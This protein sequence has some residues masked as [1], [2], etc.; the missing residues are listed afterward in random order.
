MNNAFRNLAGRTF[1]LGIGAQKSGTT[2][3]NAYLGRHPA[4]RMSPIKELHFFDTI[5]RPDLCGSWNEE[6]AA[7]LERLRRDPGVDAAAFASAALPLVERVGMSG[8]GARYMAYFDRL[9]A[10][11]APVVGEI[12]PSYSL[13]GEPGLQ[14]VHDLIAPNVGR[15]RILMLM[16][17]PVGRFWSQL[18]HNVRK[19]VLA[20]SNAHYRA[21]LYQAR[22]VERTRYELM[23][24]RLESV[25]GAGAL[26]CVFYEDLFSE[27]SL[28]RICAHL[29]VGFVAPPPGFYSQ[30]INRSPSEPRSQETSAV[31]AGHFRS[32]YEYV[33]GR[34]GDAVPEAWHRSLALTE[35]L[36]GATLSTS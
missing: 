28:R 13:I 4:I 24:P 6:F 5:Y 18:G 8:R 17:D 29:G 34:F 1:L 22:Y 30:R 16:R 11:G 35:Q 25:F 23:I 21:A 14:A 20:S 31:I 26:L 15:I 19:G 2:W 10:G 27:E 32:V 3:I 33:L 7:R 9:A 36:P 12:T